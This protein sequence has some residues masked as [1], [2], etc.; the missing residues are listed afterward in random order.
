M[1]NQNRVYW[2]VTLAVVALLS[3]TGVSAHPSH[4]SHPGHKAKAK[5]TRVVEVYREPVPYRPVVP[6]RAR[7]VVAPAY[8]PSGQLEFYR[9]YRAGQVYY[10]PHGHYHTVYEFP[11]YRDGRYFVEPHA[12]CEGHRT[13]VTYVS[14]D[15]PRLSLGFRF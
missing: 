4:A 6:R 3:T 15:G 11:V 2:I 1:R 10:A 7:I 12:Y 9:S 5:K 13:Q 14:Y 8:I